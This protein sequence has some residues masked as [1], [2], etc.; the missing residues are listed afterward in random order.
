MSLRIECSLLISCHGID[1]EFVISLWPIFVQTK[2]LF[3]Q[4]IGV[5]R[6]RKAK[7]FRNECQFPLVTSHQSLYRASI[8]TGIMFVYGSHSIL[9]DIQINRDHERLPSKLI[10]WFTNRKIGVSDFHMQWICV[11]KG[12]TLYSCDGHRLN[13]LNIYLNT[14][15]RTLSNWQSDNIYR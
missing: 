8:H 2:V 4:E 9:N 15:D 3:F 7:S 12:S 13:C 1:R 5:S 11:M 10:T 14:K 6:S